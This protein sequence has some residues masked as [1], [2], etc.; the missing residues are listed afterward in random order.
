MDESGLSPLR[1]PLGSTV[2]G[3]DGT[4]ATLSNY[5]ISENGLVEGRY[6]DGIVRTLGRVRIATFNNPSGMVAGGN[7]LFSAGV[8]SGL[9]EI[10]DPG[11]NR[12]ATIVAGALEQSN[13]DIGDELIEMTLASNHFAANAEVFR[14]ADSLLD[15]LLHLR[16]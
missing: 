16:R 3:E 4:H 9:P 14:A 11:S 12:S 8:N 15:E 1:I 2:A 10:S 13:T 6:S 7:N 5:S